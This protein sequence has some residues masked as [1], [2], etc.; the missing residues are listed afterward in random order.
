[1]MHN[2]PHPGEVLRDLGEGMKQGEMAGQLGVTRQ[3]LSRIL[4]GHAGI[5]ASMALR[6][7]RLFPN[8]TPENWLKLQ[9]NY[10][11]WHARLHVEHLLERKTAA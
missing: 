10:D 3:T 5:T 2:P 9:M 4:N 11:L 6:L 8:S 1:M 7:H